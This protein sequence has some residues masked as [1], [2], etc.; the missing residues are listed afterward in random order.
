LHIIVEGART[1]ASVELDSVLPDPPDAPE[2]TTEKSL[3]LLTLQR[4]F[5]RVGRLAG[6]LVGSKSLATGCL[7]KPR[8]GR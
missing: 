3:R 1:V 8:A 2:I 5:L 4:E 6:L 7:R